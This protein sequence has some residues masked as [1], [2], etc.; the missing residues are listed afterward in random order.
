MDKKILIIGCGRSGTKFI[1]RLLTEIGLEMGHEKMMRDGLSNWYFTPTSTEHRQ[2]IGAKI[3]FDE[4]EY[5]HILHQVRNPLDTIASAQT[6]M[7]ESWS[8]ISKFIPIDFDRPIAYRCM[9]YW[10]FWNRL[11]QENSEWT[12]R[13]EDFEN[14]FDSFCAKIQRPEFITQRSHQIISNS[15]KQ[16]NTRKGR[17]KKLT[18]EDLNRLCPQ[19]TKQIIQDAIEYGYEF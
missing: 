8:F 12:Y 13:V 2:P 7:D 19:L 17:Y 11:A 4:F 9:Q 3:K 14:Q 5:G 15:N 16:V 18:L 10:L 6:F 1:S